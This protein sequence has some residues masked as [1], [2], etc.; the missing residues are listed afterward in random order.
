MVRKSAALRSRATNT[1]Q[2]LSLNRG[3]QNLKKAGLAS[4]RRMRPKEAVGE[5]SSHNQGLRSMDD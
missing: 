1:Q 2:Q 4:Q 3:F 5:F